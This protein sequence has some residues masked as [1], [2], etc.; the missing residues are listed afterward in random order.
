VAV[1]PDAEGIWSTLPPQITAPGVAQ[2]FG[3]FDRL[4]LESPPHPPIAAVAQQP[5]FG[6]VSPCSSLDD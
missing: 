1:R 6:N 3:C 2:D 5:E 4:A